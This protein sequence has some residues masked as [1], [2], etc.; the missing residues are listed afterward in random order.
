MAVVIAVCCPLGTLFL[1]LGMRPMREA[2]AAAERSA[3]TEARCIWRGYPLS[4]WRGYPLNISTGSI[5]D[6]MT[7]GS[8][9]LVDAW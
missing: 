9:R 1:A 2:V 6:I 7:S 8:W 3:M 4:I 5:G